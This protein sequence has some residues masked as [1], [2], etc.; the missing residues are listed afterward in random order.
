MARTELR[1]RLVL[2]EGVA[3]G[4]IVLEDEWI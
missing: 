2:D 4:R 3:S 1:G